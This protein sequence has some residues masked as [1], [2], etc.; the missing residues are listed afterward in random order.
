MSDTV[1]DKVIDI[2]ARHAEFDRAAGTEETPLADLG[3]DSLAMTETIFDL[4]EEFGVE[5][6]EPENIEEMRTQFQTVG[7]VVRAVQGLVDAKDEA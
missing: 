4:E 1:S 3:V 7:D 2:L 5:I 6:P